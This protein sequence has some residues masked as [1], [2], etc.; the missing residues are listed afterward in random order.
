MPGRSRTLVL[1]IL[2]SYIDAGNIQGIAEGL[3][4][5]LCFYKKNDEGLKECLNSDIVQKAVKVGGIDS[6]VILFQH[7]SSLER[8]D[9]FKTSKLG[10]TYDIF[11]IFNLVSQSKLG[12]TWDIYGV[13]DYMCPSDKTKLINQILK[14]S[15][16]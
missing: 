6:I 16:I 5:L 1:A 12:K 8:L 10:K 13:L 2:K 14:S 11:G 15:I 9:I 7:I 4:E 3:N